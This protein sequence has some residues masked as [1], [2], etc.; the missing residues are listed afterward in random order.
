[1]KQRNWLSALMVVMIALLSGCGSGGDTIKGIYTYGDQ[2][3]MLEDC[4]TGDMYVISDQELEEKYIS[5]NFEDP[6]V[7][8]YVEL[9]GVIRDPKEDEPHEMSYI[10]VKEVITVSEDTSLCGG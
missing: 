6:Y 2:T 5:F 3:N 4:T 8:I 10:E 7:P 1:M 9:E